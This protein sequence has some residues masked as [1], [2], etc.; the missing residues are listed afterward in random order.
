MCNQQPEWSALMTEQVLLTVSVAV[1][2][3]G[4]LF[5]ITALLHRGM[6][7]HRRVAGGIGLV[8]AGWLTVTAVLAS[9]GVYGNVI[10]LGVGVAVPLV[11]G[12]LALRLPA[13]AALLHDPRAVP[14]L[15]AVQVFRLEG[16]VFLLSDRLPPAFA[17]PAGIGDVLVGLFAP[18]VAYALWRRPDRRLPAIVFNALG[19]VDLIVAVTL[20]VLHSPGPL[21]LLVTEPTSVIMGMFPMALIPTFLVPVALVLH[22]ASLRILARVPVGSTS[23]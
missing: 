6:R 2:S 16:A 18:V 19:V 17:L 5:A 21:Q 12:L 11:L 8:L 10:L 23:R 20:G 13:V 22:I 9:T 14:V 7:E 4:L 3:V 15:A 1:I